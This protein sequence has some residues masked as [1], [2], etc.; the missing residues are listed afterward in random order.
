MVPWDRTGMAFPAK[1]KGFE[2][3]RSSRGTFNHLLM[4]QILGTLCWEAA[5][6]LPGELG[7][8]AHPWHQFQPC[9]FLP[10]PDCHW[11]L[12][13]V[14]PSFPATGNPPWPRAP[15]V[16]SIKPNFCGALHL[17]ECQDHAKGVGPNGKAPSPFSKPPR[18]CIPG[19]APPYIWAQEGTETPR[20]SG[21]TEP[22]LPLPPARSRAEHPETAP[23][24]PHGI[25]VHPGPFPGIPSL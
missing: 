4:P 6:T 12:P 18:R 16:Y 11:E 17:Q 23:A 3:K 22:L 9:C 20:G 15:S 7:L 25:R 10:H 8:L 19:S 2:G 24:P 5:L 14:P 21:A 1:P 13:Q